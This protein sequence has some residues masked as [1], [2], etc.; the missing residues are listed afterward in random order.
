MILTSSFCSSWYWRGLPALKHCLWKS[1]IVLKL[2]SAVLL[3]NPWQVSLHIWTLNQKQR[4]LRLPS[5]FP[6][7]LGSW[8][9]VRNPG[10][11]IA[12]SRL[13]RRNELACFEK[14]KPVR[15]NK[16]AWLQLTSCNIKI[17][18]KDFSIECW[19]EFKNVPAGTPSWH[20]VSFL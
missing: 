14:N 6:T 17:N 20:R 11:H 7:N 9:L 15:L 8:Q 12:W 18:T 2:L 19:A 10:W 4:V 1:V 5:Y 13:V 16:L 3:I